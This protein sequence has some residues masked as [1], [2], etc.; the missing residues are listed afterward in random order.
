MRPENEPN[1]P[2]PDASPGAA[3]HPA[4]TPADAPVAIVGIGASAGGIEA[5][6]SFFEAA[7]PGSD[8]T[9]A[10][11][12]YV[13]VLHLDPTHESHLASVLRT[14][15]SM[16]VL[17][18]EDGMLLEP[19]HV[20]V[21]AP[22]TTLTVQG[23]RLRLS[24]PEEPRGH[25]HPVDVL[26]RSIGEQ[27]RER[28]I[29]V[30]L[31]GMGT[32]G[33]QGAKE[34]KAAG[35]LVLVQDPLTARFDSMP[36]SAIAAGLADHIA[37][38]G[39]MPSLLYRYLQHGYT[40]APD[41][42]VAEGDK[43]GIAELFKLL[44]PDSGPDFHHYRRAMLLRRVNRRMG[45]KDIALFADYLELLRGDPDERQALTGDFLISVTGFFRD[46]EAWDA[47]DAAID[48]LVAERE[49][50]APIRVWVPACSTGEE[51]YSVA[52]LIAEHARAALKQ[53][54][55]KVFAS[56][57]QESN[58]AVARAATYA[59]A[60]VEAMR[61]ERIAQFFEKT[62]GS[63]HLRKPLR[64]LVVFARHDLLRDPPFSRMDLICC[65]NMLIYVEPLAQ[66]RLLELFRFALRDGGILFLGSA[67][68]VGRAEGLFEALS[69]KWRLYR[70]LGSGAQSPAGFP[71]SANQPAAG[72]VRH[73]T[74][75]A[76]QP[77]KVRDI[78]RRA[79]L[80]RYAPASAL[81]DRDAKV[82][83]L[84]GDSDRYLKQPRGEPTYDL[85]LMARDGLLS[86]LR[87]ALQKV[88][89]DAQDF[90]FSAD[91][92]REE[93]RDCV[94]VDVS[95]VRTSDR[96]GLMLVTFR[97]DP[98]SSDAIRSEAGARSP[99]EF[100]PDLE[101]DLRDARAELR[102]MAEQFESV[103]EQ[104]RASNEEALSMN[105]ELQ[106]TNEELETSKEEL[107]SFNE[108]LHSIN[109]Q[110]QYKIVELDEKSADLANLL[111]G[112]DIA[113]MFL[114]LQFCV[115]WFSVATEQLFDLVAS[116]IGRSISHFARKFA[117]ERL[118]KDCQEAVDGLIAV[119]AEVRNDQGRWFVR[120]V[121]PYRTRDGRVA[122]SVITFVDITDRRHAANSAREARIYA[123]SIVETVRQPLIV[124]DGALRVQSANR[125]FYELSG[126]SPAETVG[127]R[128]YDLGRRQWDLP[129][130]RQLLEE[131]LPKQGEARDPRSTVHAAGVRAADPL[132]EREETATGRRPRRPGAARHRGRDRAAAGRRA[133]GYP[134]RRTEPPSEERS[135]DGAGGDGADAAKEF[136]PGGVRRG[137]HGPVACS[138][139]GPRPPHAERLGRRRTR[140]SRRT[141]ACAV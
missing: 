81:V 4:E 99:R 52:M 32:N 125:S 9:H 74:T 85:M 84:H 101:N 103:N 127:E 35:G 136:V 27:R 116:D 33:T 102:D 123:E 114:D 62:G 57:V 75:N 82:L 65:R 18:I 109:S 12:A 42:L 124:L 43:P 89:A 40:E 51:A 129:P 92:R 3:I 5:L 49:D 98:A 110:L 72:G 138:R 31:S 107:Q 131:V 126:G 16:A 44:G 78:A 61:P 60:A 69:K 1:D 121:L 94:L 104:L 122:G 119:E 45:L 11:P 46:P 87:A 88:A 14:H 120:R 23:S 48:R 39:D 63:Y 24:E 47:L 25:R 137:F 117:D 76:G 2:G 70:R 30:I 79:L 56:D 133:S 112:T 36:R 10:S 66:T 132:R 21:I 54:D 90:T 6:A 83:Y 111:A 128:L 53:F 41:G 15:T 91:I 141:D 7:E 29:A 28:S 38:P 58:L 19:R 50:E 22:A 26:F 130:L 55:V 17:E 135:G 95:P 106:S 96:P 113:T 93:Q 118:L 73:P 105:E 134:G 37:A 115:K 100:S 97:P 139:P 8:G 59:A 108:E 68:T 67:E 77:P 140:A 20:Y 34:I 64:D 86:P 71:P 13:V 80:E